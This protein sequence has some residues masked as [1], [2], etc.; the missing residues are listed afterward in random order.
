MKIDPETQARIRSYLLGEANEAECQA[1]ET[2]ILSDD[3]LYEELLALE[4]EVIDEYLNEKLNP[5]V[6]SRFEKHF[7][8]TPEH[9]EQ[10]QFARAFDRYVSSQTAPTPKSNP[11][12]G[13][14]QWVHSL[15]SSP[16][17]IAVFALVLLVL[18]LGAWQMFFRQ[19]AVNKGLIA[20]NAAY[21]E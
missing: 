5:E 6:R 2:M 1:I 3:E 20:L 14:Q 17:K 13:W 12:H 10:L 19:S 11:S 7:L 16:V 8:T 21:R 18:A 15:Y 9:L 4:D